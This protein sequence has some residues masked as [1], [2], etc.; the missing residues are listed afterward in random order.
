MYKSNTLEL[1]NTWGG[2]LNRVE[3]KYFSTITYK[4]DIKPNRNEKIML[5]LEDYLCKNI[6]RYSMFWIMEHTSNGYQTH[7]HLLLDGDGIKEEVNDFL[8]KKNLVNEKFIRHYDFEHEKGAS[9]YVC[10]FI[11]SDNVRYGI[12][13]S[14]D[15]KL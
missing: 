15:F 11:K 12:S 4:F 5:Q 14:D 10:K 6:D 1:V 2:W 13:Y 7:N 3:W 8:L 9:H